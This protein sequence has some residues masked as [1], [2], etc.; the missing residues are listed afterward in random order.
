MKRVHNDNPKTSGTMFDYCE[1]E[2]VTQQSPVVTI[3]GHVIVGNMSMRVLQPSGSQAYISGKKK[4]LQLIC[5]TSH[6]ASIF[7]L[8]LVMMNGLI[9][10]ISRRIS[11]T[12][13]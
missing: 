9:L 5:N 3:M 12:R 2:H 11:A 8:R 7:W 6:L 1:Y 4:V 10:E 13:V